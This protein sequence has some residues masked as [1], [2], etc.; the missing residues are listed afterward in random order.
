[1]A[2][3][4]QRTRE[5]A[6]FGRSSAKPAFWI[7]FGIALVVLLGALGVLFIS[8]GGLARP[9][10][11]GLAGLVLSFLK[12]Q[13][14]MLLF[15]TV[16]GGYTIARL[17]IKGVSLGTTAG[18]MVLG[19]SLSLWASGA[20]GIEFKLSD[21]TGTLFLNLFMFS[22]GM[23][24]G[25]QVLLGLRRGVLG[26][27]ALAFIVPALSTVVMLSIRN[28][29]DVPAGIVVGVFAGANTATPGLG[30]AKAAFESGAARHIGNVAE[31]EANM[32][33]AFAF[34]YCTSTVLFV[35]LLKLLPRWFGR[36]VVAEGKKF[37]EEAGSGGIPLPGT[38]GSLLTGVLPV[39]R[40]TYRLERPAAVGHSLGELRRLFPLLDVKA[41]IRQGKLLEHGVVPVLELGDVIAVFGPVSQLM[42]LP[43][44]V[45]HEV[46]DPLV[47]PLVLETAELVLKND[48]VEGRKLGDLAAD[49]GH[50]VYLNALFRSGELV[51]KSP[52]IT[53]EQG[54]I[55]RVTG[56]GERIANLAKHVGPIVRPSIT[57][58]IFTLCLGLSLGAFLGALSIPLGDIDLSLGAMAFLLVGMLFSALRTRNPALG[59]PF[60]EP[61]RKLFE[62]LGL[63]VFVAVLG[64]NAGMG[65]IRAAKL[66]AIT[67]IVLSTLAVGLVPPVIGWIYGQYRLKMNAAELLGA[68]AGARSNAAGMSAAVEASR[69]NAPALTYPVTFAISNLLFTT[70][71]YLLAVK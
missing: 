6:G 26:L 47:P 21:A 62:D 56:T 3:L 5:W 68:V 12:A 46:D 4:L 32:A 70:I 66:G 2:S 28:L 41:I 25:P 7:V 42:D 61:A 30:A 65:V 71:T 64:L 11:Y 19:I 35:V 23:K 17:S 59:G 36:D 33:T 40:R 48:A 8:E 63:N 57:T 22:I 45:G 34:S 67:P 20:H 10:L 1:M 50:G 54:D 27:V 58:D 39:A 49:V 24:V 13:D 60:P 29:L 44:R 53:L 9:S 51:P 69:S 55:L 16:A 38:P 43:E 14:F 52:D 18:T 15:L 31:A 37:E